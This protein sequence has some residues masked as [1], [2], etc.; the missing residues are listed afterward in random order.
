MLSPIHLE[1][2]VKRNK[3][4]FEKINA[5]ACN[6]TLFPTYFLAH[7]FITLQQKKT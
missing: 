3:S 5:L 4:V 7:L 2:L 1:V 6:F